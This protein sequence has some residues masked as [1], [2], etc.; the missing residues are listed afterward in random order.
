MTEL[1]RGSSSVFRI[2]AHMSFKIKYCHNVFDI[3][4][5][6]NRCTEL[7]LEAAAD[8]GIEITELGYDRNHVHLDI[9][10]MRITLSVDQIAKKLKGTTGRK[11]LQEFPG[12]KKRF[13]WKSGLWSPVIYGDSL[14]KEPDQIRDY[15]RNQGKESAVHAVS[16]MKF[17]NNN[18]TSL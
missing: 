6:K 9:R 15:I 8:I 10:W 13:F 5:F 12:I 2:E 1:V 17:F 14:G 4:E 3:M 16:L 11:L 7:L 18:T